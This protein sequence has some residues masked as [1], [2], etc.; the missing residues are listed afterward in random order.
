MEYDLHVPC[1]NCPFLK[2]GGIPLTPARVME[3]AGPRRGEFPCHKTVVRFDDD[4]DED[5]DNYD[6]RKAKHC[7]GALIYA[8]K[9]QKPHQMMRI[10][11][12]LG[13]YDA[14]ALMANKAVTD[15]VCDSFRELQEVHRAAAD[16][17]TGTAPVRKPH[18]LVEDPEECCNVADDDCE[19]PANWEDL[20][21]DG[22]AE[23]FTCYGCGLPVCSG[24]SEE[25]T[26]K[27]KTVHICNT[28]K[29]DEACNRNSS[30]TATTKTSRADPPEGSPAPSV[31]ASS[32]KTDRSVEA[33]S[34]RNP[35]APSSKPSSKPRSRGSNTTSRRRSPASK[36]R[37][38]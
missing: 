16:G 28:C 6:D 23:L 33:R 11:E 32:G 8:E 18:D 3:I 29:E 25:Q 1:N 37:R 17:K 36:T 12:R 34:A 30:R 26:R 14:K 13:M 2:R 4:E 9:I 24:C 7:A 5:G 10:C 27:G 22:T 21:M 35:T 20:E 15:L 38:R 19:K 31:S